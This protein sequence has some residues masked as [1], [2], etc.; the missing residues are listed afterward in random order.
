MST[1]SPLSA[2]LYVVGTP[3]G[4]LGDLSFR[5]VAVLRGSAVI[6]CEDTRVTGN[7]LRRFAVDR[8]LVAYHEHNE[9]EVAPLIAEKIV[10]GEAVAL[11]SDAGTPTISDP[12]FRL[13]R[14]CRRRRLP[15]FAVPG[16]CAAIAALSASGLP[17]DAFLFL[18]FPP[19]KTI[20]RENFLRQYGE[21]PHTLI[22]HES[23][24]RIEKFLIS[25]VAVF[26]EE[27]V[28]AVARELTKLHE[29]WH[30]GPLGVVHGDLLRFPR[31]GEFTIL[32]APK[33]F[34]L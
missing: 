20:A 9:R 16:P 4:N 8:P 18:G 6:A 2:G 1:E 28:I 5:A 15:V 11:A 31:R 21:F 30:V 22:F 29:T 23:C 33:N 14:E 24:H 13:V 19:S 12:G 32:V 7:L 17:T 27:R 26:G 10:A 34:I 25:L 3:I